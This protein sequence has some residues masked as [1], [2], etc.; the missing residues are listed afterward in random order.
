MVA[1]LLVLLGGAP[2]VPTVSLCHYAGMCYGD[3]I[4]ANHSFLPVSAVR[5]QTVL[6]LT[7]TWQARPGVRAMMLAVITVGV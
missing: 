3:D 2:A 6:R 1:V 4:D 5:A 7:L